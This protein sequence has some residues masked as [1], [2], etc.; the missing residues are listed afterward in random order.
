[1]KKLWQ[2]AVLGIVAAIGGMVFSGFTGNFF[3]GMDFGSAAVLG[4]CMYLCVVVVT[5]TGVILS[6]LEEKMPSG[7][8]H[9][10]ET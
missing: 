7:E 5:C 10:E 1:M 4:I 8:K 2:F 3:S 6:K 9:E